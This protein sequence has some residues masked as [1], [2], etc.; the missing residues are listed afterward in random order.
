MSSVKIYRGYASGNTLAYI[1]ALQEKDIPVFCPRAGTYF[2]KDEVRLMVG[3]LARIFKY[4]GGLL[5]DTVGDREIYQYVNDC[6]KFLTS[7]CDMCRSF[8]PVISQLETE[9]AQLEEGH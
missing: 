5:N 6:Y 3:C 4:E 9:L 7:I 2:D 8:E 1:K